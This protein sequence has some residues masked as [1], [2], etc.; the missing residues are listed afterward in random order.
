MDFASL[1]QLYKKEYCNEMVLLTSDIISRYFSDIDI[2]K[3][4]DRVSTEKVLFLQKADVHRLF[5]MDPE[6]K[7]T[8]C[9]SIAKFYVKVA[10]VFAAIMVT[11]NPQFSYQQVAPGSKKP[12]TAVIS[13]NFC[14]SR[15]DA[16][17]GKGHNQMADTV[18]ED[19]RLRPDIC[20]IE[21]SLLSSAPGIDKLADLYYDADYDFETGSFRGMSDDTKA[22][23]QADLKRFYT[24]FTDAAEMPP[25]VKNFGDIKLRSFSRSQLCQGSKAPFKQEVRGSYKNKLFQDYATNLREMLDSINSRQELLLKVLNRLFVYVKDPADESKK[26]V[27]INPEL[28]DAALQDIVVQ[29]RTMITELYLGCESGFTRGVKLYEAIVEA[30]ILETTQRQI[31]TMK[32]EAVR[33]Y[34][35][36]DH[37]ESSSEPSSSE[38]ESEQSESSSESDSSSATEEPRH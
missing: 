36:H 21:D 17:K 9:R 20:S 26:V 14:Q 2:A 15:I 32:T 19:V 31:A 23:F 3:M 16:L 22:A 7:M 34:K 35:T 37:S 33:L 5:D 38:S 27:R 24:A 13:L 8:I 28:N 11:I 18:D 10:H 12:K 29:T 30:Q 1:R 6:K 4:S 25:E